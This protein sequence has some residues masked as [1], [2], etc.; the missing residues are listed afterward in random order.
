MNEVRL[1]DL[2]PQLLIITIT[3]DVKLVAI[4]ITIPYYNYTFN[5]SIIII[6]QCIIILLK[7]NIG[8]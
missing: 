5:H 6:I 8:D 7:N 3:S 1:Y 4:E 2:N